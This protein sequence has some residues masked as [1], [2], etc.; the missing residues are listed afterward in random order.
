MPEHWIQ[1]TGPLSCHAWT[2]DRQ[3]GQLLGALSFIHGTS[4]AGI[5]LWPS[6]PAPRTS[7]PPAKGGRE[8]LSG[9]RPLGPS[10]RFQDVGHKQRGRLPAE[11]GT[12]RSPGGCVPQPPS[13]LWR[14][15]PT[16]NP[17]H[18]DA[19]LRSSHSRA[20]RNLRRERERGSAPLPGTSHTPPHPVPPDNRKSRK[21]SAPR[22]GGTSSLPG[23]RLGGKD[24]PSASGGQ[25]LGC[26]PT[27][28]FLTATTSK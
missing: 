15:A 25:G 4:P 3:K 20:R 27:P 8:A 7:L 14:I 17:R 5:S 26:Q 6:R 9:G 22:P 11:R 28:S 21:R 12:E 2:S 23:V 16:E 13:D 1:W 18:P 24:P 10:A 19:S